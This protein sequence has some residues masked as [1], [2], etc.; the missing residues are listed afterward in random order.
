M[1]GRRKSRSIKQT[2]LSGDFVSNALV[3]AEAALI[4]IVVLPIPP[5]GPITEITA[6][7]FS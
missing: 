1:V 2:R 3:K 4:E 7:N 5:L 6:M